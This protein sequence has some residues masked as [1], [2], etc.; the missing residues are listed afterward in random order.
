[1][2]NWIINFAFKGMVEDRKWRLTILKRVKCWK[3]INNLIKIKAKEE[4]VREME[5]AIPKH[6]LDEHTRPHE[7]R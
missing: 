4:G 2:T 5:K 7:P 1:M 3:P 6:W